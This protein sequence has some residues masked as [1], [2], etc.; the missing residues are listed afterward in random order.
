MG[1]LLLFVV[2]PADAVPACTAYSRF[3]LDIGQS[4]DWLALQISLLPCL[5]GYGMIGRRLYQEQAKNPPKKNR[6]K[7]W[8][9]NYVADDY[10]AA[11]E[12][13]CGMSTGSQK[14]LRLTLAN[15]SDTIALIEKHAGKQSPSRIEEL[16]KIF[17]Q[18][19]RVCSRSV[20]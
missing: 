14:L 15:R 1:V 11:V 9:D 2:F 16:A 19:T 18:A 8:I 3:C 20:V 4:E 7:T 5:L 17:V 6:Y 10:S 12:K 13:G